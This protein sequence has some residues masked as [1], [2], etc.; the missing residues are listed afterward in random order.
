MPN[1]NYVID[2]SF[3]PF[4]ME[5]ILTPLTLYK[6]AYDESEA[7]YDELIQKAD[8]FSDLAEKTKDNPDSRAAKIY[9]NY[10]DELH[11]QAADL[12]KHGL[13]IANKRAL[14]S[15]KRRY[16]GEI[17]LLEKADNALQKEKDLRRQMLS[18]DSSMLYALDNLSIDDFLDDNTP[19]L[20]N[21]SGDELYARGKEAGKAESSR[22]Y[23][24]GDGGKTLGDYYRIW[25]ERNGYSKESL[26][27]F[28][29]NVESIPELKEAVDNIMIEKGVEGNLQG[30]NYR[31]ARQS[32][33][34]GI[35]DGAVTE[36]SYKP[37][38][39]YDKATPTEESSEN[40]AKEKWELEKRQQEALFNSTFEEEKDD[41]GKPVLNED[42]SPR[43]VPKQ[44]VFNDYEIDPN[45]N[46]RRNTGGMSKQD[47]STQRYQNAKQKALFN[48]TV[49]EL[50]NTDGFDLLVE[51]DDYHAT[52]R[53][54]YGYIGSVSNHKDS[55]ENS[56]NL[57]FKNK[58]DIKKMKV[59]SL[60]DVQKMEEKNDGAWDAIKKQL[61]ENNIGIDDEFQVIEVPDG[62][63]GRVS[64][65]IAVPQ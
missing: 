26:D 5:E 10:A 29:Y 49:K 15:L 34:N 2:S 53:V 37:M 36:T 33:I 58:E 18:K 9:Q 60:N 50:K 19:N 28:R 25:V 43:Y 64:Y 47:Q 11:K 24:A 30:D 63:K 44:G 62:R 59:L 3:R 32:I 48:L 42:G 1:Y 23:A 17:G 7:A 46:F 55:W 56:S 38:R 14:T 40:R 21:I 39:D 20:Y 65:L 4:S 52:D 41:N 16:Q 27:Q 61:E 54:H 13:S 51:G 35:I 45:G 22:I 12:S 31:R 57:G 6:N 8:I